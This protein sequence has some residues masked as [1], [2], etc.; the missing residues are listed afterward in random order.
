M[1]VSKVARRRMS[2]LVPFTGATTFQVPWLPARTTISFCATWKGMIF[3]ADAG[4]SGR[5]R[6]VYGEEPFG[7]KAER[8]SP[9]AAAMADPEKRSKIEG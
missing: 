3:S 1:R 8:V 5:P 9:R 7:S 2:A 4:S 6:A